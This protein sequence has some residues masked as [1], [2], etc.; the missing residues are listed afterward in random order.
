MPKVSVFPAWFVFMQMPALPLLGM[1]PKTVPLSVTVWLDDVLFVIVKDSSFATH[2]A[3]PF[4]CGVAV[5][6]VGL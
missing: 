5:S 6:V 3:V 1:L 4:Q 2:V